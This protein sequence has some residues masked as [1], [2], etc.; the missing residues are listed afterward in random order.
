MDS[1]SKTGNFWSDI[2][3]LDTTREAKQRQLKIWLS[4]SEE[5][6]LKI[7]LEMMD[8]ARNQIRDNIKNEYPAIPDLDLKIE[9]FK[10]MYRHD[11]TSEK[12]EEIIRWMKDVH[13]KKLNAPL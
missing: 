8:M 1:K 5:K 13:A 7:S 9:T 11:Y 10:R 3:W 12:L 6:R 4:F 2:R